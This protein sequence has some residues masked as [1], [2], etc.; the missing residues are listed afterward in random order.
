MNDWSEELNRSKRKKHRL[1]LAEKLAFWV[2]LII[3]LLV[4]LFPFIWMILAAFKTNAQITDPNQLFR[5]KPYFGN[6]RNVFERY[7][8]IKPI[9]NSFIVAIVSTAL[10]L[11]FGLPASYA[12]AR[13]RRKRTEA[14]I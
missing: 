9:I 4:T 8:F 6:F 2:F 13:T 1:L 12:I 11:L 5:F 14:V 10:G 3:V 7:D